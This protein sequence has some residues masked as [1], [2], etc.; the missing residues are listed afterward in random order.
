[1]SRLEKLLAALQRSLGV[2]EPLR[3]RAVRRMTAR[4]K[5]QKKAET[6]A[7]HAHD[8]ADRLQREG[9]PGRSQRKTKKALKFERKAIAERDRAIVWKGRA[10]KLTQRIHGIETR[11]EDVR[12]EIKESGPTVD[13]ETSTVTGGT[14]RERWIVGNLAAVEA[15]NTG[16][17]RNAYSQAGTPDI[18]HP[19]G[20]G[21]A[22][23]RRDDCSTFT[24]SEALACGADD[25]NGE[26]F[27][28]PGYTGTLAQA[29]GRW[30]QV[31][32]AEL[33][34]AGQG[35]IVF[36]PDDGFHVEDFCPSKSDPL[37][38]VGHGDAAVNFS[39]VHAFGSG[40]TERY[41]AFYPDREE[42]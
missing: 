4:H 29:H 24:T 42:S 37:R 12:R 3:D 28:G 2:Q 22:S 14:F 21:P 34:E 19:F 10:R 25:P 9:H 1:M 6:Q 38:T 39:T 20:P 8:A 41:Y 27:R 15:C 31:S 13:L 18:W 17:R 40:T 35:Y 5:G 11:I 30:K 26:D 23:G 16:R 36:G 7:E 32:L 33:I